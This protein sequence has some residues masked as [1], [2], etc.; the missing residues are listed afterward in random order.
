MELQRRNINKYIKE[1]FI[2]RRAETW[3]IEQNKYC[4]AEPPQNQDSKVIFGQHA[5]K[6]GTFDTK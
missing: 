2:P 3:E 5:T 4:L 1:S 6:K